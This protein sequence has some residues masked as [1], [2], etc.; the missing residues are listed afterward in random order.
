[1]T[2]SSRAAVAGLLAI[3]LALVLSACSPSPT[4]T[5]SMAKPE[6]SSSESMSAKAM[7][8]ETMSS[9]AMPSETMTSKAMMAGKYIDY[10]MYSKDPMTYASSKVVLFFH[11]TWCPTCK[12]ADASLMKDGVPE[13]L[14]VVKVDYDSMTDLKAK[15][16]ITVQHT[17]VSID[18]HG[19]KQKM[20]SG[21]KSGKE[22]AGQLM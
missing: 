7:P 11:A 8:S 2:N 21:S 12:E 16:G 20:W 22:I 14:T 19:E 9:K 18:S 13:G 4:A 5:T 3:P 1:M 17:F 15:Y 6:A 10:A